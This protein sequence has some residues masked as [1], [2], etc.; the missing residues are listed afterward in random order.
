MTDDPRIDTIA[1]SD[2]SSAAILA[3]LIGMLG[4]KGVISDEEV[5]EVYKQALYLL[6]QHQ[7]TAAP[8]LDRIYAAAR[9]VIE[10]QLR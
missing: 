2:L 4:A 3:S 5:R 9:E 7:A 6:E 8:E 10:A 1:A